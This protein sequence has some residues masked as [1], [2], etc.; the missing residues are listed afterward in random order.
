MSL[1]T[2][3]SV[4]NLRVSCF[5]FYLLFW[6]FINPEYILN[7]TKLPSELWVPSGLLAIFKEPIIVPIWLISVLSIL[8]KLS[9][10]LCATGYFFKIFSKI[11]FFI[12]FFMFNIQYSYG[13]QTHTYLPLVLVS[14]VLAFCNENKIFCIRFVF[15]SIFFSAGVSKLRNGGFDWI[16]SESMQNILIRSEIFYHDNSALAYKYKFNLLLAKNL[17]LTQASAFFV[18]LL[19]IMSPMALFAN[20]LR[21][22]IVLALLLT[23][24]SILFL[25]FVNFK[26]YTLLYI[27]WIN[28]DYLYK[29]FIKDTYLMRKLLIA[30]STFR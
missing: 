6:H 21:Y 12:T 19:E 8:W 15:C 25:I 28:W 22:P 24:I 16:F 27:F 10:V 2:S 14:F 11:F 29:K 7:F 1:D 4:I 13:Y 5:F 30:S 23:Q 18:V 17:I 3:D 26:V 9:C 20:K